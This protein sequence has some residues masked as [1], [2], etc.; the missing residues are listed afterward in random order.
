MTKKNNQ[1]TFRQAF[2]KHYPDHRYVFKHF[3]KYNMGTVPDWKDLTKIFLHN[4]VSYLQNNVSPNSAVTY[5]S[6]LKCV[7]NLY[8]EEIKLPTK[9]YSKVLSMV[10]G[11]DTLNVYLND[12]EIRLLIEHTPENDLEHTI[13]NQFLISCL[14]GARHGDSEKLDEANTIENAEIFYFAQKTSGIVKMP[15]PYIVKELLRQGKFHNYSD[16]TFNKTIRKICEKVG[17][18]QTTKVV[19]AGKILSG[20]K[21]KFITSHTARRSFATNLYQHTKDLY[22]VCKLMGHKNIETTMRYICCDVGDNE[23]VR[24][25]FDKYR[26]TV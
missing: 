26:H 15:L 24:S 22:L 13:L 4:F 14:T 23:T 3:I 7:M 19:K 9:D 6:Y 17:I 18:K 10:K 16:V 25:F 2:E 20:E 12:H 1:I 11:A 5:C 8:C 21:Y